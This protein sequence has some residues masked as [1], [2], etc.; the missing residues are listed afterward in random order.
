[1]TDIT[2]MRAYVWGLVIATVFWLAV[3]SLVLVS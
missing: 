3:G 2:P 1:M